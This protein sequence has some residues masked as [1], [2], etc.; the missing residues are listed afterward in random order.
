MTPQCWRVAEQ[1]NFPFDNFQWASAM[2]ARRGG[3]QIGIPKDYRDSS[4]S[5]YL[6]RAAFTTLANFIAA[7][8]ER[9]SV[10]LA[11]PVANTAATR[12]WDFIRM[13]PP[14]FMGS[15]SAKDP[16]KFL[17]MV[18]KVMDVMGVTSSKSAKLAI[19]QL[20]DVAP[21]WF[22][23][24]KIDRG[25]DA[26]PLEWEEF[27]TTF[28]DRFFS[29]ELREAK[30]LEFNNLRQGNMSIREYSL[31]FTQFARYAPHV[32]ADNM[33][34]MSNFVSSIKGQKI[35]ERKSENKRAGMGSFNFSQPKSEGENRP[36]FHQRSSSLAPSSSSAPVPKFRNYNRDRAL[37]SKFQVS[38]NSARTNPLCQKCGR[39][40]QDK[41]RVGSDV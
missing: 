19:Y 30:V 16:K 8:N 34:K 25:V 9:P 1:A 28:L 22:K 29:L 3:G 14:S 17:D 23:K 41:C 33:S 11:N 24:W 38:V 10:V 12:I 35:K 31:K 4:T 39:H 2:L 32:V 13:N 26:G 7:Q 21:T 5:W 20:Q 15:K 6:S 40:H 36:Q 18:Q 37:G 27:A